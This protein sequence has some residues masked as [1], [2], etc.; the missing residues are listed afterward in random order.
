MIEATAPCLSNPRASGGDPALPTE[1]TQGSFELKF[2]LA[3][4]EA[5]EILKRARL[6]LA[7]DPHADRTLGDRYR[8]TSL[9]FDTVDL[10]V[11]RGLGSY[12]RSKY[13]LRR[14][15]AEPRVFLERKSK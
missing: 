13:R 15:G 14:Y 1:K 11:H 8:I 10:A 5:D 2:L 3:D 12:G 4:T 6:H 7:A 9:Y